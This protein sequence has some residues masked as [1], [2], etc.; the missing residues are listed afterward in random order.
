MLRCF[1]V[2]GR[3]QE[4]ELVE[5]GSEPVQVTYV[6][7]ES[8]GFTPLTA[9]LAHI[10]IND[11]QVQERLQGE[12]SKP[13]IYHDVGWFTKGVVSWVLTIYMLVFR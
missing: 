12:E 6:P 8:S 3:S 5:L 10:L 1:Q 11:S 7:R 2:Q 13:C 9:A 4:A